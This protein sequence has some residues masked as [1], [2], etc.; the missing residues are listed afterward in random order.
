[1]DVTDV[2]DYNRELLNGS[3]LEASY[4]HLSATDPTHGFSFDAARVAGHTYPKVVPL[5]AE[6]PEDALLQQRLLLG[7]HLALHLRHQLEEQKGYTSTVGISTTK[8]ISK[9]VGNLNKPKGQTTLLPPYRPEAASNIIE[10]VD[11]HDIG[12]IP[13][14]GF[15]MAQK[16]RE[17]ILGRAPSFE[18]GL[19]YGGTKENVT[20]GMVRQ[21][22]GMS[23]ELLEKILSGAGSPHGIGGKVFCLLHGVDDT[24][25]A[26]ARNV[27]KQLSIEDSYIRLDTAGQLLKELN[28][29]TTRLIH[30]MRTDLLDEYHDDDESKLM[31]DGEEPRSKRWAGRPDTLRL[32]TRPKPPTGPDGSRI[33]S[34]KRISRAVP[35]PT[36]VFNLEDSPSA[37]AERLVTEALVPL[38]RK[39]HPERQGWNVSLINVAVTNISETTADAKTSS[40]R[41][42]GRMFRRQNDVL[43]GFKIKDEDV[44]DEVRPE[45]DDIGDDHLTKRPE[46]GSSHVDPSD[47]SQDAST[48]WEITS[49]DEPAEVEDTYHCTI[50]ANHVPDFARPAH[51]RYHSLEG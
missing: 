11:K 45:V 4:F 16:L 23:P 17:F 1:M 2:I 38:F 37:I 22:P 36:F 34:F 42:I 27:P 31:R 47:G 8:M 26:E 44:I 41:D 48:A 15:K 6:T 32:T 43:D 39:L 30:Q 10:F 51:D 3:H 13:W 21:Y 49:E 50:C 9:L 14:I 18:S 25:V 19:V 7:S 5:H 20:T 28:S 35:L 46:I 24:P 12:S 40:G 33:R 29:L